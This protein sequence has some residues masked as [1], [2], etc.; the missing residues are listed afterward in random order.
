MQIKVNEE[1]LDFKLSQDITLD[2]VLT[3]VQSWADDKDLFI[4]NYNIFDKNNLKINF[5]Y[6]ILSSE[7]DLLNI[8]VGTQNDLYRDSLSEL[9]N[10]IDR[11]GSFLASKIKNNKNLNDK[12]KITIKEGLEWIT[13]SVNRITK[14]LKLELNDKFKAHLLIL[15][16]T[17]NNHLMNLLSGDQATPLLESLSN[18]KNQVLIWHK[19][20][21][22]YGASEEELEQLLDEFRKETLVVL[23]S[24]EDIATDLTIGKGNAALQKI[25]KLSNF[26]SE[27]LS[28]L[29]QMDTYEEEKIKLVDIL[30]DLISAL[31]KNDLITA[32]DL[33]DYEIREALEKITF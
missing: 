15:E 32:A 8:E 12:E 2:E 22:Y 16:K 10:Y 4:L 33:V 27:V 14:Q 17:K 11:M 9:N 30:D 24:L 7:I 19:A 21:Q 23:E 25:E 29:Y 26:I 31:A 20:F 1:T 3:H 13:E 5:R 18:I 28:L 6:D